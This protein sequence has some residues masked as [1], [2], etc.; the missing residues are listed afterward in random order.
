M[1]SKSLKTSE[2][3]GEAGEANG[4]TTFQSHYQQDRTSG[5]GVKVK[6]GKKNYRV[7]HRP[8]RSGKGLEPTA[9][10]STIHGYN[11]IKPVPTIAIC[12]RRHD[13]TS[14]CTSHDRT[15]RMNIMPQKT[16]RKCRKQQ[17]RRVIFKD[18][19]YLSQLNLFYVLFQ[20][21]VYLLFIEPAAGLL[22]ER[23][24]VKLL[25]VLHSAEPE[26][27]AVPEHSA[28]LHLHWPVRSA[29]VADLQLRNLE[30]CWHL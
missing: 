18:L 12:Q 24:S 13:L 7:F 1:A 25:L 20:V 16:R 29:A 28:G 19:N 17:I 9:N 10:V 27:S 2:T 11:R 22:L 4:F 14:P 23:H 5:E 21:A 15:L 6:S 30:D 3:G 26:R 8:N